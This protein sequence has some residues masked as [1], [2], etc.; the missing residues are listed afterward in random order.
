MYSTNYNYGTIRNMPLPLDTISHP[1]LADIR[2]VCHNSSSA[3]LKHC[4]RGDPIRLFI[5]D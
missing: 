5:P 1:K 2:N 4:G 3:P